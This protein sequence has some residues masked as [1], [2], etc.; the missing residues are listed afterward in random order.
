MEEDISEEI[1]TKL[2]EFSRLFVDNFGKVVEIVGGVPPYI[3]VIYS[4]LLKNTPSRL[5]CKKNLHKY[6]EKPEVQC[7]IE[8]IA[9][10]CGDKRIVQKYA[11]INR[12]AD[13]LQ[14]KSG[15][16]FD[17]VIDTI[18]SIVDMDFQ[19]I[20]AIL[21]IYQDIVQCEYSTQEKI[22][23]QEI[24]E[25]VLYNLAMIM[26]GQDLDKKQVALLNNSTLNGI[27]IRMNRQLIKEFYNNQLQEYNQSEM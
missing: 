10:D 22:R 9:N 18:K 11:E 27:T 1:S 25:T 17:E 3:H 23:S 20:L 8:Y 26:A 7:L 21:A 2:I 16:R 6:I 24:I 15:D 14:Q 5:S 12:I 13:I 19:A 4:S